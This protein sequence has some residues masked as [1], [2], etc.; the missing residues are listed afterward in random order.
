M[1]H[2][3]LSSLTSL[4]WELAAYYLITERLQEGDGTMSSVEGRCELKLKIK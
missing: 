3:R 4:S 1:L 2:E